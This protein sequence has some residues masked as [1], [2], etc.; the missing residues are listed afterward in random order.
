MVK[1]RAN[2][3]GEA[4]KSNTEVKFRQAVTDGYD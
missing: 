1:V 4:Y 3:L 2:L